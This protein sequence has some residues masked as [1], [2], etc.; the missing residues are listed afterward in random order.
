MSTK[1]DLLA[2][3]AFSHI[4]EDMNSKTFRLLRTISETSDCQLPT[5]SPKSS[6]KSVSELYMQLRLQFSGYM[7]LL[8]YMYF[9]MCISLKNIRE[10][11]TDFLKGKHL[12]FPKD[13]C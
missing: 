7:T 2:K 13:L 3:R 6:L 9:Q 4:L 10:F 5:P 1:F 12:G 8:Q 11:Q